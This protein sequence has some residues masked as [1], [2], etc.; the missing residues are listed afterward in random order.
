MAQIIN[1]QNYK[2]GEIVEEKEGGRLKL[3]IVYVGGG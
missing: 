3:K 2:P 1:S